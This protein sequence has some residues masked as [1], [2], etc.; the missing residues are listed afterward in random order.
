MIALTP[1][2]L[3]MSLAGCADDGVPTVVI[4]VGFLLSGR[5]IHC[6]RVEKHACVL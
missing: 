6:Q 2:R 4:D 1:L 5:R 3:H